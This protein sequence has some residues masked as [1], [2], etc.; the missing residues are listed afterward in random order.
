MVASSKKQAR[1]ELTVGEVANPIG[2]NAPNDYN[3]YSGSLGSAMVRVNAILAQ[4]N[5]TNTWR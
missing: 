1:N 3:S 2:V 5:K 4:K